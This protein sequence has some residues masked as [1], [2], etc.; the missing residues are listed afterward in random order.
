MVFRHYDVKR[1]ELPLALAL[2]VVTHV[3]EIPRMWQA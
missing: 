1:Q 3:L 2:T